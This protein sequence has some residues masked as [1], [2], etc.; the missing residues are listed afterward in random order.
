M[1][2]S[3]DTEGEQTAELD[4]VEAP[5]RE[6]GT[7]TL[8]DRTSARTALE[9]IRAKHASGRKQNSTVDLD[10]P[11]FDGD[12]KVRYRVPPWEESRRIEM[13]GAKDPSDYA[14]LRVMMDEM[15]HSCDSILVN[16]AEGMVPLTENGV[17]IRFDPRLAEAF[18][19]AHDEARDIVLGL[20]AA[21]DDV[22][23]KRAPYMV[24]EHYS[25]FLAWLRL[26]RSGSPGE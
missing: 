18:G 16:T 21:P 7:G 26:E 24:A 8:T 4:A 2:D 22:G 20:F 5:E 25:Q 19:I 9:R 15:I 11:G 12:V 6:L 14:E 1:S 10:V 23:T 3:I 17:L 13:A